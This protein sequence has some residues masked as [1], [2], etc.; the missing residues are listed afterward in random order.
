M[1]PAFKE[2]SVD[3][4][5]QSKHSHLQRCGYQYCPPNLADLGSNS[6]SVL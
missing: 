3:P 5:R 1:M 6:G 2:L 4:G